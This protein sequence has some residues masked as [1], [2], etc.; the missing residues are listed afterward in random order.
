MRVILLLKMEIQ[1]KLRRE[2]I[3][4]EMN[5]NL[6]HYAVGQKVRRTIEDLGGD[7]PENLP[8]AD[9]IC[10]AKTRVRKLDEKMVIEKED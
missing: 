2:K 9:G 7:M 3:Q 8:R 6:T 4:G 1:E 10:Q 5:A